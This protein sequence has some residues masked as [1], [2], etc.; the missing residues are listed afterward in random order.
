MAVISKRF[1][2]ELN[3]KGMRDAYLDEKTRAKLAL[4]IK[5]NRIQRGLSQAELGKN[6]GKT[7]SNIHRL[8]DRDVARYTLTTLLEFASAYDCGLA[9]E[10]VP[11]EAFLRRTHDLS[12]DNLR[13]P[14][15]SREALEPLFQD[16]NIENAEPLAETE[17]TQS[18]DLVFPPVFPQPIQGPVVPQPIVNTMIGQEGYVYWPHV[19][20]TSLSGGGTFNQAVASVAL[21]SGNWFTGG[22]IYTPPSPQHVPKPI[23]LIGDISQLRQ[24]P[25]TGI[26]QEIGAPVLSRRMIISS[27]NVVPLG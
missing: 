17:S 2:D 3:E 5:E 6:M 14:S 20:L 23:Q 21:S 13:V 19:G 8:E 18:A 16:S 25:Y 7:Q 26:D 10:F 4:Q 9:V 1:A 27:T 11:Y 24:I 22:P 15:F 12:P